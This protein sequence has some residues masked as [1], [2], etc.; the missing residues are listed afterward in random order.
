VSIT[1]TLQREVFLIMLSILGQRFVAALA[2]FNAVPR[3]GTYDS[4][5]PFLDPEI[6]MNKVDDPQSAPIRGRDCVIAY[7]NTYQ[8]QKLPRLVAADSQEVPNPVDGATIGQVTGI[9]MYQENS[10]QYTDSNGV[11]PPSAPFPVRYLFVFRKLNDSWLLS[12][13]SAAPMGP[14]VPDPDRG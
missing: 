8:K 9:G 10:I 7:L 1:L 3:G 11:H 13:A 4:L 12:L 14:R 5:V 6:V 2:V